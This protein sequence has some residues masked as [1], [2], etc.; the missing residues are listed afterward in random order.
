MIQ[1]H[2]LSQSFPHNEWGSYIDSSK[3]ST[4]RGIDLNDRFGEHCSSEGDEFR[5]VS[6]DS[7]RPVRTLCDMTLWTT[8]TDGST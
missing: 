3:S 7:L 1:G 6:H 2:R 4:R 5:I 8:H